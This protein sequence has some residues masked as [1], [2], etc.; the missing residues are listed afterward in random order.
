VEL[1]EREPYL[2]RLEACLEQARGGS[3]R[4]V[5]LG[6]EAGAGKTSLARCFVESRTDRVRV[7][8]G[9]CDPLSTPR[10]LA[11]F[12]DMPPVAPLLDA[13]LG[14]YELLTALLGELRLHTVLVAE[15]VHWADEATLDALRFIGRRVA[16]ARSV[17]VATYRDDELGAGHPLRAVLGDLATASGCER[18]HVPPLSPD[19]VRALAAGSALDPERLHRTTGGNPFYVSEVLSAPG[20]TVPAS[21]A[22]AVLARASRLS[23]EARALVDVVSLS[24]GGLETEIAELLA[25]ETHD[26]LDE[27][28]ERGVLVASGARPA[29][30]RGRPLRLRGERG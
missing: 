30:T 6:G 12:Y 25:G 8:W 10:A 14:R 16:G 15:D 28:V 9:A 4:L 1:V 5:L 11:P 13:R 24:P 18:L 2:D 26:A 3:G 22:D 27:A 7:L 17:V 19:G 23:D 21:V 20:L 29:G